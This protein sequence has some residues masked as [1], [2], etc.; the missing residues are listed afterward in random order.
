[1]LDGL[2][3]LARSALDL[4]LPLRCFGCGS[5]VQEKWQVCSTCWAGLHFL[6]APLCHACGLPHAHGPL[7]DLACESCARDPLPVERARA[8]LAYDDG[9]RAMILAFKHGGR[10]EAAGLFTNWMAEHGRDVLDGADLLVPVP[11]HRWRLLT[12]GFN[13]AGLL[14]AGIARRRALAWA[15]GL[16]VRQRATRSQQG[17]NA[18]SRAG[19]VTA[20]AFTVRARH[21]AQL[22]GR[23]VVLI[24]D[25]LTTGA[26]LGACAAV[27]R[28][29]GAASVDAL[30][31]ARVVRGQGIPI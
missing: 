4:L 20:D 3:H 7:H 19:N 8:A 9:S 6:T 31:L 30:T 2:G 26:T 22:A 23:R 11:L 1:M 25:V 5:M 29:H 28:H 18:R 17:L 21:A 12:R 24:D 16:L 14:A 27:L 10:I 13:Q 15:P